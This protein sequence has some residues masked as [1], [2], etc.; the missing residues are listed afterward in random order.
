MSNPFYYGNPVPPEL[1]LGRK[2]ELRRIVNRITGHAQSTA[3]VGEPR[4][5]KTSLLLYL[6]APAAREKLYGSEGKKI[7]FSFVDAHALGSKFDQ[8]QFWTQALSPLHDITSSPAL[9]EAY[10]TCKDN[11]FGA[12]VLERLFAQVQQAGRRLVLM[13]DEFDTLLHHEALNNAEFFGSLRSLASRAPALSLVIAARQPLS[14]LNDETQAFNRTGS[15]YFNFLSEYTLGPM[16]DKEILELLRHA[17]GRFSLEERKFI[18]Q[19]AGAHPYLLQVAA[20]ALWEAY[21]DGEE[22]AASRADLAARQLFEMAASMLKNTWH[23]WPAQTRMAMTAIA[24]A[25]A[26]EL[27]D[28]RQF[29]H[30]NLLKDM[31]DFVPELRTLEKQGF[32]YQAETMPGGWRI[33]PQ[34]FLWWLTDELIRTVRDEQKFAEWLRTQELEGYLTKG[35]RKQFKETGKAIA[36]LLKDDIASLIKTGVKRLIG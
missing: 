33:R 32:I 34:V 28:R 19:A 27:L 26:P 9:N 24:L 17:A 15:P 12:F 14:L 18:T 21:E 8:A 16:T 29:K 23:L 20:S 13:I 31:R 1:F 25:Q 22:D 30:K 2:K 3:V 7:Q 35:Q 11:G 36:D 4:S 5:G 6:A 10:Q